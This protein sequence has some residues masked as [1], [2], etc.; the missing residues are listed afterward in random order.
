MLRDI[1]SVFYVCLI[2]LGLGALSADALTRDW[3]G[4][5]ALTIGPWQA[6][7][8]HGGADADPYALAWI[9]RHGALPLGSGEG[10]MLRASTDSDGQPLDG[11]CDYRLEGSLAAARV[12]SLHAEIDTVGGRFSL[13]ETRSMPV[14]HSADVIYDPDGRIGLTLSRRITPGSWRALPVDEG[15]FALV[16]TLLDTGVGSNTGLTELIMPTIR[17]LRCHGQAGGATSS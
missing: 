2:A 1:V 8:S 17:R 3:R 6:A 7:I 10:V 13:P 12:W 11:L 15:P 16:F 9:A 14:A 5:G 4:S